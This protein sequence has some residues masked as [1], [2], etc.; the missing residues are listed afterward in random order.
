MRK[1]LLALAIAAG[2]LGA[3]TTASQAGY[4]GGGH[5]YYKPHYKPYY[6][7]YYR[8]SGYSNCHYVKKRFWSDYHYRY[9]YRTKRVCY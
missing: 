1:T 4:Y 7:P 5:G 2:A 9:I 8:Y 3:A 6:K